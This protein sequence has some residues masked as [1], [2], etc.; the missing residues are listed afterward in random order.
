MNALTIAWFE[1][2]RRI[3][4]K[5]FVLGT[6]GMPLLIVALSLGTGLI[7]SSDVGAET[8]MLA[9]IDETG[10][11]GR[12]LQSRLETRFA[13]R[14]VPPLV[15]SV[16]H[17]TYES[18][19]A[20]FDAA[21]EAYTLDGYLVIPDL[22]Y[23]TAQARLYA[24]NAS[25]FRLAERLE[26][27]LQDILRSTRA[28]QM[29]VTPEVLDAIMVDIKLA[30]YELGSETETETEML[31]AD[32]LT[33]VIFMF[34]LFMGI[35]TGGQLLLRAVLE[36]R[37]NRVIEVILSTVTYTELMVGKILGLGMLGLTQSG[38]YLT[39]G[40]LLG[41]SYGMS[42][43]TWD[44]SALYLA[45][46]VLG[47][48]LFAGIY[49]GIGALFDSEQEAQQAIQIISFISL[50]PMFLWMMVIENPN[51]TFVNILSYIPLVTPFI[52]M[53]KIALG[54]TTTLQIVGTMLLMG[55]S[56]WGVIM[57]AAKI[58][59]TGILMYGKRVTLPEI[60]RWLR[61]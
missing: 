29:N 61:A 39:L 25:N 53:I 28:M 56:V 59:R 4:S 47:Y 23:T 8:K 41:N 19:H 22:I 49:I 15:L 37:S 33:P 51:S 43:V 50:I 60:I 30:H 48:L 2:R 26:S 27:E 14:D 13:N 20:E 36:E 24:R 44:L 5:W 52:M 57:A 55:V 7:A 17:G 31:I 54:E 21:V 32:Y 18:L 38:I 34:L 12:Q 6:F 42:I 45:Y 40:G 11:V 58:F 1:Y 46:F 35:F 10:V 16:T 9:I 3:R